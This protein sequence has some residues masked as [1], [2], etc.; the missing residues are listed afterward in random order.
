MISFAGEG[1]N[2][3][4]RATPL[5]QPVTA[6]LHN[7]SGA[8]WQATYSAPAIKNTGGRWPEFIDKAD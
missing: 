2:V 7:S 1:T 4:M 3:D 6:Q 5:A 8:C